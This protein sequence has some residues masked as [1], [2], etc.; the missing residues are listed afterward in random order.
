MWSWELYCSYQQPFLPACYKTNTTSSFIAGCHWGASTEWEWNGMLLAV[1]WGDTLEGTAGTSQ[2]RH[3]ALPSR[4]TYAQAVWL[5]P[6]VSAGSV[7]K[8]KGE[9]EVLPETRKT[10]FNC[11]LLKGI[12]LTQLNSVN[13]EPIIK[14]AS[15]VLWQEFWLE[16]NSGL[17]KW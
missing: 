1:T 17:H 14:L 8:V 16:G 11:R 10:S 5:V 3:Q 7:I 9:S 13:T 2:W 6:L 4:C 15:W 12:F